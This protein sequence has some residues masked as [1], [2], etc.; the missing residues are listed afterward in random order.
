MRKTTLILVLLLLSLI[1]KA[2]V[3]WFDGK[4]PITYSVPK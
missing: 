3:V 1:M 2:Q 4:T